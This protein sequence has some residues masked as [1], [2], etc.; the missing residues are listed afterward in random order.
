MLRPALLSRGGKHGISGRHEHH[1][2]LFLGHIA[3]GLDRTAVG[4]ALRAAFLLTAAQ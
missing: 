3:P 2:S 1:P 4:L